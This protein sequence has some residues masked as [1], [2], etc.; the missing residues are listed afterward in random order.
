MPCN[1]KG[2]RPESQQNNDS[3]Y[4]PLYPDFAHVNHSSICLKLIP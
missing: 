1:G 4:I 3:K 2:Q